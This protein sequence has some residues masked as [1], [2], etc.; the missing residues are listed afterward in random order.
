MCRMQQHASLTVS[1]E[2]YMLIIVERDFERIMFHRHQ[3]GKQSYPQVNQLWLRPYDDANRGSMLG[4]GRMVP[5]LGEHGSQERHAFRTT[6]KARRY[7]SIS[8]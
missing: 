7:V 2:L 4:Y 8:G 3:A 6:A 1:R 5:R